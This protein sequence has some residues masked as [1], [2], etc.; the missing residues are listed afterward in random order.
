MALIPLTETGLRSAMRDRCYW[1]S[2][3]PERETYVGWVSRGWRALEGSPYQDPSGSSVV[4]VQAYTRVRD[5]HTEQVL[6]HQRSAPARTG[7]NSAGGASSQ[8]TDGGTG[9]PN[10][11]PN[12]TAPPFSTSGRRKPV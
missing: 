12:G 3:H 11:T 2:G 8:Q 6:A 5:G 1:Q 4:F 9:A 7:D 10:T